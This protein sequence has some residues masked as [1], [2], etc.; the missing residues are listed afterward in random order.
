MTTTENEIKQ[1]I[2]ESLFLEDIEVEDIKSDE[3]LFGD[4]LGLDS[5]D[6]LEL[7]I[8]LQK[9]YG[10]KFSEDNEVNRKHF[11]TVQ[12]LVEYVQQERQIIE[13]NE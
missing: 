1:L 13:T 3:A 10:L 5:I 7:G 9:K 11:A 12:S 4:G 6:A 8:A 2:I